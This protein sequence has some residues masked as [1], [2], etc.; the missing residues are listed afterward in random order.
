M[1]D[2][3]ASAPNLLIAVLEDLRKEIRS[4][5]TGLREERQVELNQLRN[6]INS[7]HT[8]VSAWNQSSGER[9]AKAET[10]I[11]SGITGS[12]TSPSRM[13][14]AELAIKDLQKHKWTAAGITGSIGAALGVGAT[15]IA[16]I[17]AHAHG[18]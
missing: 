12:S 10:S 16:H 3:D 2:I 18:K 15:V 6:E 4:G 9:I 7:F 5:L 13:Y 1:A 14:E 8:D 11:E 17:I